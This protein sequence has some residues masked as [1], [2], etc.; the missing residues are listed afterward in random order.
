MEQHTTDRHVAPLEHSNTTSLYS[1]S[2]I[3]RWPLSLSLSLSLSL[4]LS[5]I[6]E[7]FQQFGIFHIPLISHS[8]FYNII[9]CSDLPTVSHAVFSLELAE[10]EIFQ[11][12]CSA[13]F[14]LIGDNAV[15]CQP[16]ATWTNIM[17]TCTSKYQCTPTNNYL[18]WDNM[19]YKFV[20]QLKH[21][22]STPHAI[23]WQ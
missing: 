1:L 8:S 11:Y 16:D 3:Y 9:V 12:N 18:Y 23:F 15:Q 6:L 14:N 13:G 10:T 7:Q 4:T 19:P 21:N 17:F 20:L 2:Y 22:S 5:K